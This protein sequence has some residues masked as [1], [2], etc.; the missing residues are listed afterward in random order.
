MGLEIGVASRQHYH[1]LRVT[2]ILTQTPI[3]S[4]NDYG[5]TLGED[6]FSCA[7]V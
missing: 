2:P 7:E 1:C 5:Q 6:V 3:V 4:T